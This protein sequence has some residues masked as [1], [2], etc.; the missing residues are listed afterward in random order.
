MWRE[1]ARRV[2]ENPARQEALD[3]LDRG[4]TRG[5]GRELVLRSRTLRQTDSTKWDV[6][7]DQLSRNAEAG[8]L[9]GLKRKSTC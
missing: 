7:R 2:I 9:H 4:D 1:Y 8:W 5:I 3:E 6:T